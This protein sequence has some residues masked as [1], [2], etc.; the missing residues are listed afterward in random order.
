[1]KLIGIFIAL[2]IGFFALWG[3]G[4]ALGLFTVPWHAAGNI[5]DTKHDV[6]D[7]VVNADN[8]IYNYEW[9]KQR[10]EDIQANKAKIVIADKAVLDFEAS[11]GAR[12]NW[13]FQDKQEDARL[14]SIAQGLR[15][16]QEQVIA[17]YN[18]RAKMA[19]RNIFINGVVPDFIDVHTMVGGFNLGGQN[20]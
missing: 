2:V 11:A 15:G 9:F 20:E 10:Y 6:I 12:T 3:V 14:R 17:D 4:I 1:M 13:D 16:H 19:T 5:V 8:A 18:A 7:K